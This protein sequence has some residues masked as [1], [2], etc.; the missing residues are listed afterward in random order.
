MTASERLVERWTYLRELL[1][2]QLGDLQDGR[3]TVHTAG[4]NVSGA[5]AV[6]LRREIEAF[7]DLLSNEARSSPPS[8]V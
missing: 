5:A 7:D 4:E 2:E 8:P 1:L 3:V 6:R